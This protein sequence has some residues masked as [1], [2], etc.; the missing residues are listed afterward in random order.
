MGKKPYTMNRIKNNWRASKYSKRQRSIHTFVCQHPI[1]VDRQSEKRVDLYAD[2]EK[3]LFLSLF[4]CDSL[5][6]NIHLVAKEDEEMIDTLIPEQCNC[7]KR[8]TVTSKK[9]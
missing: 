6:T 7:Q 5:I 9:G 2:V 1:V 3:L 4:L 8:I